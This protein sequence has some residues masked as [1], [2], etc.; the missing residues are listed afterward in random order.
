M[1]W[2]DPANASAATTPPP[3]SI[4]SIAADDKVYEPGPSTTFPPGTTSLRIAYSAVSLLHPDAVRFRHR[5][6]GI[7]AEWQD[8]GRNTSVS[9]R[10]LPPGAYR[11][12]VGATANGIWWNDVAKANFTILPA[13]YQTNWFRALCACLFLATLWMAYRLRVRQLQRRFEVTLRAEEKL[14]KK[15]NALEITRT[16]SLACRD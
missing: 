8:A 3:V 2:L 6:Q 10:G 7:D 11:F 15:D 12:E 16:S 1:V 14:R 9:Y 5:L 4:Q 13:F